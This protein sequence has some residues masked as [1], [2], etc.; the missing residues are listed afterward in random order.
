MGAT[1]AKSSHRLIMRHCFLLDIAFIFDRIFVKLAGD[2]D[3]HKLSDD[4][5]FGPD[6][7]IRLVTVNG[8]VTDKWFGHM[9]MV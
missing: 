6:P 1:A 9:C 4:I 8:L 5:E 3:R 2:E 7:T